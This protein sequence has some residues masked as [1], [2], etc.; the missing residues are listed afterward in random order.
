MT[1]HP[2][3]RPKTFA[4][5][6]SRL[7]AGVVIQPR[8]LVFYER[9]MPGSQLVNRLQDLNYRVLSLEAL[10]RLDATVQRESPLLLF[11]DLVSNGD[12]C[13]AIASLR[14]NPATAHL[15]VIAFAPEQSAD[16]LTAAQKAGANIAVAETAV[17]NHLGP[18]IN[19]ALDLD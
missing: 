15:P 17:L 14:A 13:A 4:F 7:Q 2:P 8:A 1:V 11:I 12:I 16:L 18:L 9:L 10:D 5:S 3:N 6:V 19:Q